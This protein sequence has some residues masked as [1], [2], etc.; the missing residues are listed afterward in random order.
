MTEFRLIRIINHIHRSLNEGADVY[1]L[2]LAWTADF[3]IVEVAGSP[4]LL[5]V[6]DSENHFFRVEQIRTCHFW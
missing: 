6:M 3:P 2:L 5:S 1:S 4:I